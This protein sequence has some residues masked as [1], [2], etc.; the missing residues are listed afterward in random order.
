MQLGKIHITIIATLIILLSG[1]DAAYSQRL[2][3]AD[4][5][6]GSAS[7]YPVP[8]SVDA[9]PDSLIPIMINHVGR[10]GAR[11]QSSSKRSITLLRALI[12]ADS[13][14]T[15]T[16]KGR[17]LKA[18]VEEVVRVTDGRWGALDSIG[19]AEQRGIAGRMYEQFK[20]VFEHGI[21]N[22]IS[23][24]VPR[25]VMS[26]YSFCH[27]LSELN[28]GIT[29]NTFSSRATSPIL[30]PFTTDS[31]YLEYRKEEPYRKALDIY[32]AQQAPVKPVERTLGGRYPITH[33]AAQKFAL[34]EYS[35]ISSLA[36]V[37]IDVDYSEYFTLEE[38][39]SLWRCRNLEQYYERVGNDFS[40]VPEN[41]AYR[42]VQS[43]LWTADAVVNG[44]SMETV[45]LRFGHAET[46]MPFLSL[47]QVP[48]CYYMTAY[49]DRVYEHW[50]NFHVVPMA[51]NFRM[52]L[53]K[54]HTGRVY[55][56]FDF[57]EMPVR[58]IEDYPSDYVPWTIAREYLSKCISRAVAVP[59]YHIAI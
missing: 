58:L 35:F 11:F 1:T 49:P 43:F 48:E 13:L 16:P 40:D 25:C 50:Q 41:I 34:D 19:E 15:I 23:S 14:G 24:Y 44:N 4:E 17:K 47:M 59:N 6:R 55:A 36:A 37:G 7:L 42:L 12:K 52:I 8:E 57:N 2:F 3:S 18:L 46:M 39:N 33:E 22:A 56:R 5:C 27:Q 38:Y 53:F 28:P 20:P 26:M 32:V 54:S 29:I 45:Q 21:V 51:S 31:A 30:R 10:H 9:A